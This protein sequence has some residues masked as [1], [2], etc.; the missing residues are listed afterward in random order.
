MSIQL[1]YP[2]LR[3]RK[4][5]IPTLAVHFLR[6]FSS[7]NNK[8]Y[9]GI[10]ISEIEKLKAYAW[11][12]NIR[13]LSNVI[14]RAVVISDAK[15]RFI[16]LTVAKGKANAWVDLFEGSLNYKTYKDLE[17]KLIIEALKKCGGV[18]GGENGA[19]ELLGINRTTLIARMKKLGIKI[20]YHF[21]T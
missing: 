3:E 2:P 18:L 19:S 4:E 9:S 11:P 8:P 21:T 6:L 15:P 12:G 13:E 7:K 16:D 17:K 5:D 10:T 1:W 20:N 14:E